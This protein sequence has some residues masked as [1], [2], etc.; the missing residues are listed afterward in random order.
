MLY[1]MYPIHA[2]LRA[3]VTIFSR[4]AVGPRHTKSDKGLCGRRDA[5]GL[6]LFSA[7][8]NVQREIL[9]FEGGDPKAGNR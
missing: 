2:Y 6:A 1:H 8:G 7:H 5:K 3:F 4:G 9:C